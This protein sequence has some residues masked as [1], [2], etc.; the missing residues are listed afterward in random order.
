MTHKLKQ[1]RLGVELLAILVLTA[2]AVLYALPWLAPGVSGTRA[3]LLNFTLMLLLAG[4]AM[5]WRYVYVKQKAEHAGESTHDNRV[6]QPIIM[7]AAAQLVGLALTATALIGVHRA[8]E[9]RAQSKFDEL[10]VRIELEVK[11]RF[12]Q[13]AYGLSGAAGFYAGSSNVDRREFR[14]YVDARDVETYFPGI[15]GFGFVQRV[16]RKDLARFVAAE[17]A[18][19]A[20]DFAVRSSGSASDLYVIKYV[21]PLANNRAAWGYDIGSESVR[22]QA[23]E[24][25]VN[26]GLTTLTG[27]IVL[28][29]HG[30]K[31]PGLLLLRPIYQKGGMPNTPQ[32]RQAE[33]VGIVYS[34]IVAAEILQ[35]VVDAAERLL[36]IEVFD[37]PPESGN[38]LFNS[39]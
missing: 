25:A 20:S 29:Q 19:H 12:S 33:L 13:V 30:Q 28:V 32:K 24:L 37:G 26:T 9:T 22:R 23:A 31:S 21:E 7:A 3:V 38:I 15:R 36:T 6:R 17:Q 16:M 2:V 34:P 14:A 39:E 4:P 35:N 5:F 27:R 11:H 10:A 18:D 1:H 8:I